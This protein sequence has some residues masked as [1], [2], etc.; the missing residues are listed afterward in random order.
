MSDFSKKLCFALEK[1]L[2]ESNLKYETVKYFRQNMI[3]VII[4]INT[5]SYFYN[6]KEL[7]VEDIYRKVNEIV[8]TSRPSVM[9]YLEEAKRKNYLQFTMSRN[10]KRA[11]NITP[12]EKTI[13]EF[14]KWSEVFSV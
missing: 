7:N 2:K 11:Y 9:K 12:T 13:N 8:R 3:S 14:E 10:D 5:M 6:K 4:W 1:D